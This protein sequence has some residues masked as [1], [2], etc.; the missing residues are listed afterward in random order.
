MIISIPI[1]HLLIYLC[2]CV[3]VIIAY[4]IYKFY[5]KRL[6]VTKNTD[7]FLNNLLNRDDWKSL[8]STVRG[9]YINLGGEELFIHLDDKVIFLH[10]PKQYVRNIGNIFPPEELIMILDKAELVYNDLNKDKQ[11]KEKNE[12]NK[13]FNDFVNMLE[14]ENNARNR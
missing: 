5:D 10:P 11:S 13:I 4:G 1:V 3:Y 6:S 9:I 8:S 7:V 12:N 2:L 14:G